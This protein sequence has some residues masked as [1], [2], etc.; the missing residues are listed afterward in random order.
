MTLTE[1]AAPISGAE[2]ATVAAGVRARDADAAPRADARPGGKAAALG[3]QPA[4]GSRE[5]AAPDG[6]QQPGRVHAALAAGAEEEARAGAEAAAQEPQA[7]SRAWR[8]AC[9]FACNYCAEETSSRN[10]LA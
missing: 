1:A 6:A 5:A 10:E 9:K 8:D 7:G 2:Q 4:R 3:A